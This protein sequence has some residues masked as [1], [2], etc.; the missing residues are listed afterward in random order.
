MIKLIRSAIGMLLILTVI[1]G[2]FYPLLIT[3]L[4]QVIFPAQANGSLEQQGETVVGSALIGQ[5]NDN[6]RYFWGRPSVIG[7]N[8]LPSSGSNLSLTNA[9]LQETVSQREAAFR[10]ANQVPENVPVPAEMLFASGSGLDP[11][12]SPVAARLQIDR[13]AAARGFDRGQLAALVEHYSEG[14]QLG[15]LG[16][17]RVNV[18]RLNRALDELK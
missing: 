4:A 1:T 8:P 9:A 6:S 12:I 5:A 13:V 14:P 11:H 10:A 15:F 17:P 18:L 16:Q 7:Y 3:V 2:I